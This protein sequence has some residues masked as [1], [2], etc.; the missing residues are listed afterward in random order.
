MS[1]NPINFDIFKKPVQPALT[2]PE[3]IA[4]QPIRGANPFEPQAKKEL[5]FGDGDTIMIRQAPSGHLAGNP[6]TDTKANRLNLFA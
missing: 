4:A 2:S 3:R 6:Q 1:V 5:A